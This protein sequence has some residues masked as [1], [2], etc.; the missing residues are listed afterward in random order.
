MKQED[1]DKIVDEVVEK[2]EI[3]ECNNINSLL[4]HSQLERIH[5]L[6]GIERTLTPSEIS[7]VMMIRQ[8]KR[9]IQKVL[10]SKGKE[11]GSV[12]RLH[13]FKSASD[14]CGEDM[15]LIARM[16]Q[17]K[18]LISIQDMLEGILH[19]TL[20]LIDEKIGDAINYE[21]LMIAIS[22]EEG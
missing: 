3:K 19:P 10:L 5:L 7:D 4:V 17:L 15:I 2:L 20:S 18:H 14:Y 12:D 13:N 8:R 11:Y 6:L 22:M 9:S 16:F 21:I 1:F